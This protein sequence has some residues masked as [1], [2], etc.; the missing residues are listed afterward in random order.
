MNE[1]TKKG[2]AILLTVAML[3]SILPAG[4]VWATEE[5]TN[6][7]TSGNCGYSDN[8]GEASDSVTW[9][10]DMDTK[11][12]TI[13][14]TGAMENPEGS[15]VPWVDY[16]T[17]IE[18]V[19]VD[20]GVVSISDQAF[21]GCSNLTSVTISDSVTTIGSGAF[22]DCSSLESIRIPDSVTAIGNQ[23]FHM[24]NSLKSIKL[25]S[26]ITAIGD[27]MFSGCIN[28]TS[29]EIPAG[30]TAI[31]ASAFN[32]CSNLKNITI[33]AGVA[34][35][36]DS[37][38]FGSGLTSITIPNGVNAIG[39]YAFYNCS[40]LESVTLPSSVTKIDDY[41]F[42]ES[43]LTSITIP[44]SV[45]AIDNEA[46]SGC[47]GL[48]TV[49]YLG[50]T[51]Y[52]ASVFLNTSSDLKVYVPTTYSGEEFCNKS[53][54]K[55]QSDVLDV[56]I[57]YTAV[58]NALESNN[59]DVLKTAAD[60]FYNVTD[61]FSELTEE[62]LEKVALLIGAADGETAYNTIF[63]DWIDT[64]VIIGLEECYQAYKSEPTAENAAALVEY[65]EGC[66]ELYGEEE[67]AALVK[68]MP[69]EFDSVYEEASKKADSGSSSEG[70]GSSS[71]SSGGGFT[72]KYNY[73]VI[74]DSAVGCGVVLS[75]E[76]AVADE[77][78]TITVAPDSGKKVQS[79]IVTDE[80]GE[81][82]TVGKVSDNNYTFTMPEGEVHIKVLTE[83]IGYESMITLQIGS[84]N[85]VV[86][87]T[88]FRND[89]APVI[90][91]DRTMVPIRVITETLGGEADWD[92]ATRT[93]TLKIDDKVLTL[94]IGEEI[95]G[96][97]A[98]P[99]I[100]DSRTYVPIRYVAE[101]MGYGVEW[102]ADVQQVVIEK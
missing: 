40:G 73:P 43:G 18:S 72:G 27:S 12:L 7:V 82:I 97:G 37:A 13:S 100:L 66:L 11:T 16:T 56:Y 2:L 36:G 68:F 81:A 52:G 33:P 95:P 92:E 69:E 46:F 24:C 31:G 8:E 39:M 29:I 9:S 77:T 58:Q 89:V 84:K 93:V 45:T 62:Q 32:R 71:S 76:Y 59:L 83:E 19:V 49:I 10:Y 67:F 3:F 28:L 48:K 74:I 102:M 50:E 1:K 80:D 51:D 65:Y 15:S 26:Q 17:E 42:A 78:V 57:A 94:T 86:N 54:V 44:S 85:I 35:I 5:E 90:M 101:Y 64:N 87:G 22:Q 23:A 41:A 70:T 21:Y 25:P 53:V 88:T 34:T 98:A 20:K 60:N 75:E 63:S 6:I 4:A 47:S 38:F 30:V 55:V 99:I 91:D 61:T 96:F 79:V 14:G